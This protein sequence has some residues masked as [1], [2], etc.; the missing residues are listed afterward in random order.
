MQVIMDRRATPA[1][2]FALRMYKEQRFPK[3]GR[4]TKVILRSG[5]RDQVPWLWFMVFATIIMLVI[6]LLRWLLSLQP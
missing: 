2:K 1:G 6:A 3:R 4:M 5:T